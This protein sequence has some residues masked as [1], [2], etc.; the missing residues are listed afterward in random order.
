MSMHSSW[1]V[2]H[3]SS[4]CLL[5]DG[6]RLPF[7]DGHFASSG[8]LNVLE[9][10][11]EPEAF[12]GELVRVVEPGGR[13]VL[14]SP[15]FLRV[16]GFGY[17][18]RM[19]GLANKWANWRTIR[20]KRRQIRIDPESVRFERMTPIVKTPFEP[21]DDAIIATN[22]IEMRFFLERCGC[23]VEQ[24]LCT[25]RY[26]AK[27]IDLLLNASSLRYLMFNAF[28]VARRAR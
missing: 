21:D 11:E 23:E 9:H 20:A 19:K 22:P 3:F 13:I 8:A 16:L 14:S 15:N 26:V 2:S 6:K 27:P 17:H 18:P 10:V 25:D 24:V 4:Q 5:Y 7:P 12:I 28:L 1:R